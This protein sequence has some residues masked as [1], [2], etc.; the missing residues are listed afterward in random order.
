MNTVSS[1]LLLDA[2]KCWLVTVGDLQANAG[3][4]ELFASDV[5]VKW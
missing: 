4:S 5:V 3:E 1:V 2:S